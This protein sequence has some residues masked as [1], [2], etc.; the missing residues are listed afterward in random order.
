MAGLES[1]CRGQWYLVASIEETVPGAL[2]ALGP[3]KLLFAQA[4]RTGL[5]ESGK[6]ELNWENM[7]NL[8]RAGET[9]SNVEE[10]KAAGLGRHGACRGQR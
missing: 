7:A 3:R 5:Q 4:A 2:S 1:T 9:T 8:L 10:E 6:E